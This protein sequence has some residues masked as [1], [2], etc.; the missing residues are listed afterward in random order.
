MREAG[1]PN[2]IHWRK[3]LEAAYILLYCA[4]RKTSGMLHALRWHGQYVCVFSRR[5]KTPDVG[6]HNIEE[7]FYFSLTI[8]RESAGPIITDQ[9]ER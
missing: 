1:E 5:E 8:E 2:R 6:I 3:E 9:M 7:L 4:L